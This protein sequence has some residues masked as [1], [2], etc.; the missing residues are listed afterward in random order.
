MYVFKL[1]V[2]FIFIPFHEY[3]YTMNVK[4]GIAKE[5]HKQSRVNFPR[6]Y[7]ELKGIHDLYQGDLVE[8]IPY[9]SVNKGYKYIMTIINCFTKFAIAVPLKTKTANEVELSLR[10]ILEKYPMRHFQTDDGGE[11]FNKK[12]NTLF[13]QYNVNHYSTFSDK[14]ASI[15][16]RFNRTLKNKMWTQFSIQGSYRWLALLPKLVHSYNNT[17]H[18]T[19]GIKPSEV[20][21][22]N[23]QEVLTKIINHRNK[24]N[25]K[26]KFDVGDRVRISRIKHQFTKGYL[27]RWSNEIFTV[28]KVQPTKPVTYIL[29]D[30]NKEIIKGGFYQEE[31]SKTKYNDVYLIEKIVKKKGDKYLIKWL[32]MDSSKNT[33]ISKKDLI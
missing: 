24:I 16:E 28:W 14:K 30:D 11:W 33:W 32:G 18:N 7:V 22:L 23:E 20:N 8:V 25:A 19:I 26:Q 15:V 4:T 6:R 31:L 17:V 5:L 21:E 27:P 13:K 2:F 29:Q 3:Y 12:L 9:S 10:P 1:C